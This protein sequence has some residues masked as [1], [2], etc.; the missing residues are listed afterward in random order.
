MSELTITSKGQVTLKKDVLNHLG[1]AP[2]QKVTVNLLPGGRVEVTAERKTG[3]FSDAFGML[4]RKNGPRLTIDDIKKA[5]EK[6][7]A[8]KS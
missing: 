4:H 8:G 6:A 5:T 3:T 1:V 7:W 2:G